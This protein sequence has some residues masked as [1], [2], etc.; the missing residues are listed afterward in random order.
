MGKCVK[1]VVL[2]TNPMKDEGFSHLKTV[3]KYLV[4]LGFDIRVP[5][6]LAEVTAGIAE[7]YSDLRKLYKGADCAVLLGGDGTILNAA[8]YAIAADCPMLGINLGRMGYMSELEPDEYT[9]LSRLKD[10]DYGV[11]ERM[12]LKVEIE[13]NGTR[14]CVCRNA[15]NDAVITHATGLHVIDVMLYCDSSPV[16]GY[17]GN[18]II[19]ATPTGSTAYGMAAGGPVLDPV[20]RCINIVPI[21]SVSPAAK[22]LVFSGENV[23]TVRNDYSREKFVLLNIDGRKTVHLP[24]GAKVICTGAKKKAKLIK[25]KEDNKFFSVL[26]AKIT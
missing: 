16:L 17:R 22:P 6:E 1:T 3:L 9:L 24:Y 18:G 15:L 23:M 25:L 11:E 19:I 4:D 2:V 12:T 26:R 7:S 10:G 14:T 21:C 20:L 8:R 5:D 13:N